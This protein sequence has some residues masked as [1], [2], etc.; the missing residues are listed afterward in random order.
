M[1]EE[2]LSTGLARS[3]WLVCRSSFRIRWPWCSS[4][5]LTLLGSWHSPSV[6][7]LCG[8]LSSRVRWP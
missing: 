2:T 5:V 3:V 6:L 7:T 8:P 4:S 1:S